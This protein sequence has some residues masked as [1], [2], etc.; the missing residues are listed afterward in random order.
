[1]INMGCLFDSN[2]RFNIFYWDHIITRN[3]FIKYF[4]NMFPNLVMDCTE[5]KGIYNTENFFGKKWFFF[6]KNTWNNDFLSKISNALQIDKNIPIILP[7]LKIILF[8]ESN[9]LIDK[10]EM[11]KSDYKYLLLNNINY[12]K[13]NENS[14][15]IDNTLSHDSTLIKWKQKEFNNLLLL[16]GCN[17]KNS[18]PMENWE[19]K[20]ENPSF[21]RINSEQLSLEIFLGI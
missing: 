14:I 11:E 16:L 4:V 2:S 15:S 17:W 19:P 1:M 18:L 9:Q 6:T 13:I 8:L 3:Q 5:I 10:Y 20:F 21:V 12:L 7:E